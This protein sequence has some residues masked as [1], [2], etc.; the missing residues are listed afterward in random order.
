ML[1]SIIGDR[2]V[3]T[4]TRPVMAPRLIIPEEPLR[5]EGWSGELP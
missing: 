1:L 4:S 2:R 5:A 3:G